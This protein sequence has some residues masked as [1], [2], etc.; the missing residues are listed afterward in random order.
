VLNSL[1]VSRTDFRLDAEGNPR[2]IEINTLPGLTPGYSDLCLQC[3]AQG[4]SYTDLILE[5]LYLGASRFGLIP[6]RIIPTPPALKP[7]TAPL[8]T[9]VAPVVVA[10]AKP[11][12]GSVP[13][14]TAPA[15]QPSPVSRP[16]TT[17]P[18]STQSTQ[19][20]RPPAAQPSVT[21]KATVGAPSTSH[22]PSTNKPSPAPSGAAGG[23]P[24][25][26]EKP[27]EKKTQG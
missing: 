9:A 17:L 14:T 20:S 1:D 15:P 8:N 4:I 26:V 10:N 22:P 24:A 7:K 11:G 25:P 5:I 27:T 13:G 12:A 19:G 18:A 23:Q 21:Q 16:V 3:D 6:P 2:L